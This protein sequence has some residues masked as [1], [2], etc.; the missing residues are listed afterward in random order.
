MPFCS[1]PANSH[2]RAVR[3]VNVADKHRHTVVAALSDAG[4]MN[5]NENMVHTNSA[6]ADAALA[7]RAGRNASCLGRVGIATLSARRHPVQRGKGN[8]VPLSA[9][10]GWPA[11]RRVMIH[12]VQYAVIE[13]T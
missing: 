3:A 8:D 13:L 4:A 2:R 7:G 11:R 10:M 9:G 5:K 1:C 6:A 12:L